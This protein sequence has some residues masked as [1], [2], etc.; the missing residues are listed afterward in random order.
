LAEGGVTRLTATFHCRTPRTL[1]PV[2]SA[3]LVDLQLTP[4]LEAWLVH[5]AASQ[6]VTDMIWASPFADRDIDEWAGDPAFYRID[7]APVGWLLTYTNGELIQ[8]VIASKE[9]R[10][11][12]RPLRGWLFSEELA[13]GSDGAATGIYVPYSGGATS[14]SYR[15][16][17]GA[18][19][20]WRYQG[21]NAHM[22][23]SD[24]HLAMDNVVVLFSERTITP[25][26]EDSLGNRSLHFKLH[27]EGRALLFRDGQVWDARWLREGENTLI[28]VVDGQGDVISFAVGQTAVQI[29]STDTVVT[30][31]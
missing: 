20:Y 27:G 4:M 1:G 6:P 3:R 24:T 30:W 18:R 2:R 12:P 28:R 23:Q 5:V 17:P 7:Q 14:V 25:I 21:Q 31:E 22:T 11:L 19:R 8:G 15:Y 16:D 13:P 29:V 10:D 9:N 26:V